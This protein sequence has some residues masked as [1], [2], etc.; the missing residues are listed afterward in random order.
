MVRPTSCLVVRVC[1]RCRRTRLGLSTW[2]TSHVQCLNTNSLTSIIISCS[3]HHA[4]A[5]LKPHFQI[6]AS[7]SNRRTCC[8]PG[9]TLISPDPH[10]AYLGHPTR[11]ESVRNV[12]R[13]A[14]H[15]LN[16]PS[17]KRRAYL[18]AATILLGECFKTIKSPRVR[19]L[20]EVEGPS[21]PLSCRVAQVDRA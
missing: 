19:W 3:P 5:L 20:V 21:L 17:A 2:T 11:T 6:L 12:R 15:W 18:A 14:Y 10:L 8:V 1:G 13:C 16:M 7:T 9:L 4:A